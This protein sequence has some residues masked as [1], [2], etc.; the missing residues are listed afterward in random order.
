MNRKKIIQLLIGTGL[1]IL[2][3]H[4]LLPLTTY[5]IDIPRQRSIWLIV[6][7]IYGAGCFNLLRVDKKEAPLKMHY[8]YINIKI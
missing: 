2:L 3:L 6:I 8:N 4:P 7:S 5:G 1:L